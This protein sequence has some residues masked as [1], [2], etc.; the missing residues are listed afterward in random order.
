MEKYKKSYTELTKRLDK[1][2]ETSTK[3]YY[4]YINDL[5]FSEF[6]E[7]TNYIINIVKITLQTISSTK[8][9]TI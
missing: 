5:N 2:S 3:F 4:E 7:I 1:E 9:N 6:L 8:F